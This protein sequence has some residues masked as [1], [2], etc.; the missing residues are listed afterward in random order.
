MIKKKLKYVLPVILALFLVNV[1]FGQKKKE[2]KKYGV[3]AIVVTETHGSKTVNDSKTTYDGN[4]E[5]I[6]EVNYDKEGTI[7]STVKYKNNKDGDV[8]E[9]AEYDEKGA[10]KEKRQYK[11]NGLGEKVEELVTDKDNKVL[12]KSV[13]TYDSKGFKSEKKTYDAN[14]NLV[15]T[16]KYTYVTKKVE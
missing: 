3:R 10:L 9:E 16:K 7:K 15:S 6:E 14:N 1:S 12:K 5:V 4:G 8:V 13:Y 11:Y 2:I